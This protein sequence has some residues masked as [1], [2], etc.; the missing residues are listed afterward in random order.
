VRRACFASLVLAVFLRSQE[1]RASLRSVTD[2]DLV[3]SAY[4]LVFSGGELQTEKKQ[5]VSLC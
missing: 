2:A 5:T 3:C 1:D 4:K